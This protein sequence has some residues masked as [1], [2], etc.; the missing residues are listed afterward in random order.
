MIFLLAATILVLVSSGSAQ[1]APISGIEVVNVYPHDPRA[2]C[3]GLIW[4]D[5]LLYEGTG[6]RGES[7]IRKVDLASGRVLQQVDL[8][9]DI[10]G[11][12][13]TILGDA[14]IQ[15]SWRQQRAYVYDCETL[16]YQKTHR[17]TGEGW[18]LTHDGT[19]L[20]MSDG[21][22]TLRFL[23]PESFRVVRRV[24]V[25]DGSSPVAQLNEL[26][27]V[28]GEIWANI[29]QKDFI[30]RISPSDGRVLGWIDCRSLAPPDADS[31][32]VLNG[33]A[34][35]AKTGRLFVTGKYWDKLYEI[36]VAGNR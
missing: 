27:Y 34:F 26:E 32:K 28:E 4:H 19:H 11:E 22:A 25:R 24:T 13:I 23:D 2:F 31:N 20:I 21:T 18:G 3:Q 9:R 10:F 14:L 6:R 29:W 36:R 8:N 17:Y 1:S 15:L 12:G 16:T 30:A 33:I 5:G 7:S 35:D